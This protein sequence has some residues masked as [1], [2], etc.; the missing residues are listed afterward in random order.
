MVFKYFDLMFFSGFFF[1]YFV[2]LKILIYLMIRLKK[3]YYWNIGIF[4]KF[5]LCK[6]DY[7]LGYGIFFFN[8][9]F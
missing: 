3:G 7:V 5:L 9:D 1:K 4:L 6:I 2:I 8:K